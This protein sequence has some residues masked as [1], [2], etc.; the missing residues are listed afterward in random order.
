MKPC[1]SNLCSVIFNQMQIWNAFPNELFWIG[2]NIF[3]LKYL[4]IL[5]LIIRF[6][7]HLFFNKKAID[8]I[9]LH[10]CL[11]TESKKI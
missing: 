7:V 6:T 9:F 5:Y 1:Y 2:I 4:S 8:I 3:S 10:I 11:T